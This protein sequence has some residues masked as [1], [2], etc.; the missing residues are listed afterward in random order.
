[1]DGRNRQGIKLFF[2]YVRIPPL[3]K[4]NIGGGICNIGG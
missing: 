1:M 2:D 3:I 4:I